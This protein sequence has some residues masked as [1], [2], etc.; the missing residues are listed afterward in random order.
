MRC[1]RRFSWTLKRHSQCASSGPRYCVGNH[2]GGER[3]GKRPA[4]RS[5]R[6]RLSCTSQRNVTKST[7]GRLRSESHS[8]SHALSEFVLPSSSSNTPNKRT[9]MA[10]PVNARPVAS[11]DA[12]VRAARVRPSNPIGAGRRHWMSESA[13]AIS[14]STNNHEAIVIPDE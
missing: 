8:A 4:T 1:S 7:P 13:A 6:S 9:T 11:A 3:E 12:I 5:Q 10:G 2:H 14:T